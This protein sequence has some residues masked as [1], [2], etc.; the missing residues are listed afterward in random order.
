MAPP[1]T[2]HASVTTRTTRSQEGVNP[3]ML[4]ADRQASHSPLSGFFLGNQGYRRLVLLYMS[5]MKILPGRRWVAEK[6]Q[7]V[8]G[9][10]Q[11]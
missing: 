9:W 2:L 5:I 8:L 11:A 1:S 10:A 4:V 6:A 3:G 7:W